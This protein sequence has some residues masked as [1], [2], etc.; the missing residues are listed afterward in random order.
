MKKR[1]GLLQKFLD[2]LVEMSNL[3][4][5]LEFARFIDPLDNPSVCTLTLQDVSHQGSMMQL[6]EMAFSQIERQKRFLMIVQAKLFYFRERNAIEPVGKIELDYCQADFEG[7]LDDDMYGF[8]VKH[9]TMP[10]PIIF[11]GSE[12]SCR[13][14]VSAIRHARLAIVGGVDLEEDAHPPDDQ[15]ASILSQ[16]DDMAEA[17]GEPSAGGGEE[18]SRELSSG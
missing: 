12:E 3:T 7:A 4:S 14:W 2:Q 13:E 8:S 1:V 16:L 18:E 17:A 10:R 15:T 6:V 11:E 5:T 9:L